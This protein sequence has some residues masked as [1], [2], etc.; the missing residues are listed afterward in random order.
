MIVRVRTAA[1]SILVLLA[2]CILGGCASKPAPPIVV[3][4]SVDGLAAHYIDDPKAEMPTLRALASDGARADSMRASN[5][6]VT[7]PNH[8][9]L[10]TGV[11]PARHGVVG[12]NYFDRA[13][14]Q[15]RSRSSSPPRSTISL[16]PRR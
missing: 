10:V 7:W 5:P 9:T 3:M 2:G 13:T 1:T 6:T 11:V 4:I 8:T 15:T 12:N 14:Q 16:S